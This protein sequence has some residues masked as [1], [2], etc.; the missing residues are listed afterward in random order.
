M[1]RIDTVRPAIIVANSIREQ[2]GIKLQN[3]PPDTRRQ[4][5]NHEVVGG[6]PPGSPRLEPRLAG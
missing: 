5:R 1:G 6:P 2:C 4:S 3:P